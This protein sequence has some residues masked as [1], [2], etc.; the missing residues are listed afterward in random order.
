LSTWDDLV[1]DFRALGGVLENVRLGH[2]ALGRGLFPIE[3][4]LPFRVRL[5]PNLLVDASDVLFENNV[6]K[7]AQEANVGIRERQFLEDYY[8]HISWGGGGRSEIERVFEQAAELPA[9]LRQKL[10]THYRCGTWFAEPSPE[11][12]QTQFIYSRELGGVHDRTVMMPIIELANCGPVCSYDDTDGLSLRGTTPGEITVHSSR[13]RKPGE[14]T[15]HESR[16]M[17]REP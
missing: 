11:L 7:I 2:G 5:P 13:F 4:S 16:I 12:T 9:E 10:L 6:F 14:T 8:A 3:P 15:N 1:D 17:T